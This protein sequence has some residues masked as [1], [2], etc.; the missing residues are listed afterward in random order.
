MTF[1]KIRYKIFEKLRPNLS[2][3]DDIDL[4]LIGDEVHNQRALSLRNEL[5]RNRTIDPTIIQDL[6]CVETTVVDRAECCDITIGCS[7]IRTVLQIPSTIELHNDNALWIN[8]VDKLEKSFSFISYER[9]KFISG[10]R[11]SKNQIYAFILNNYIYLISED[12]SHQEI[13]HISVRGVFENPEEA[14]KFNTCEGDSC[15]NPDAP[16]PLKR[17]MCTYIEG[18]A[19]NNLLSKIKNPVD[20][21][22]DSKN[23]PH[24]IN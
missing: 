17:W 11:F 21:S 1:N 22:A 19:Y 10:N 24:P 14:S 13:S 4:R 18:Q 15:F 23:N 8:P 20:T 5:N 16:Y 12:D 2:D 9:A 6:G 3:D 7:I